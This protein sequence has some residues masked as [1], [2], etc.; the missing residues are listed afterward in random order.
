MGNSGAP[1]DTFTEVVVSSLNLTELGALGAGGRE[2]RGFVSSLLEVQSPGS[3]S[4]EPVGAC[5][6]LDKQESGVSCK[7]GREGSLEGTRP[8]PSLAD[9]LSTLL[10]VRVQVL[11]ENRILFSESWRTQASS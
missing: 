4:E 1:Q 3:G 2:Q 5:G 7:R 6:S 9:I 8:L 10:N 11:G